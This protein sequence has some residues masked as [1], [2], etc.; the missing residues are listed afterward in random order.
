MQKHQVRRLAVIGDGDRIVGV[1]SL[2][3][4]ARGAGR[5]PR[6]VSMDGIART[7]TAISQP[8]NGR[9]ASAGR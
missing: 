2:N 7:L 6:D 1:L 8:R 9:H 4:L 5:S 3:D